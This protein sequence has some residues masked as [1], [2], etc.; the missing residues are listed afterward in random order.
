LPGNDQAWVIDP[1]ES[2]VLIGSN[3][4]L[5]IEGLYRTVKAKRS[6]KSMRVKEGQA[7][8]FNFGDGK[9]Q[10]AIIDEIFLGV[11]EPEFKIASTATT[12]AKSG[13]AVTAAA[14]K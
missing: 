9:M 5:F 8:K 14:S 1:G 6:I 2:E 11:A 3:A 13:S 10:E 7:R 4:D 12:G